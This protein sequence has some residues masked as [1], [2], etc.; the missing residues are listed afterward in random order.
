MEISEGARGSVAIMERKKWFA[1]C[2]YNIEEF[3]VDKSFLDNYF[4]RAP[5]IIHDVLICMYSDF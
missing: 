1:L 2:N 4:L 3:S 5:C